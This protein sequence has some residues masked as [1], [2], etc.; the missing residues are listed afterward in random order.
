MKAITEHIS[1]ALVW[2]TVLMTPTLLLQ[3]RYNISR[4]VVI[5]EYDS[6][7][8]KQ[9]HSMV[10]FHGKIRQNGDLMTCLAVMPMHFPRETAYGGRLDSN[11]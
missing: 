7:A 9:L 8:G 5:E 3:N 4:C 11:L 1:K 10:G 6:K 2:F